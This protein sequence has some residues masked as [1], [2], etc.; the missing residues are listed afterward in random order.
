MGYDPT[1]YYAPTPPKTRKMCRECGENEVIRPEFRCFGCKQRKSTCPGCNEKKVIKTGDLY[2]STCKRKRIK[3]NIPGPYQWSTLT[4]PCPR[5]EPV[6][7]PSVRRPSSGG[8]SYS[9]HTGN[10]K[11]T[12]YYNTTSRP[13]KSRG[14]QGFASLNN[15][16]YV[17]MSRRSAALSSGRKFG[18]KEAF[19]PSGM[20]TT[21]NRGRGRRTLTEDSVTPSER[22]LHRRRLASHR[23]SQVL[24]QLM[25][26]IEQAKQN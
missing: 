19:N 20:R 1:L 16:G 9:G 24:H 21:R 26:E 14:P 25:D 5:P 22:F 13:N 10:V 15:G 3:V 17:S 8:S 6:R 23:D 11:P 4:P 12:H 7:T 18:G 2:C